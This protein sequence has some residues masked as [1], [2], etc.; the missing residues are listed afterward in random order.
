MDNGIAISVIPNSTLKEIVMRKQVGAR[1]LF[2][3][4][5]RKTQTF[6]GLVKVANPK[7]HIKLSSGV[8]KRIK[9]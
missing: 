9:S 7:A 1:F 5:A 8:V 4:K 3:A 2:K 6:N